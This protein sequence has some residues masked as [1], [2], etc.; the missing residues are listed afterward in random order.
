[1]FRAALKSPQMRNERMVTS[2]AKV[3]PHMSRVLQGMNNEE[4]LHTLN[5]YRSHV[6]P[7][8][9]DEQVKRK[10]CCYDLESATCETTTDNKPPFECPLFRVVQENKASINPVEYLVN[11]SKEISCPHLL[12]HAN[13]SS[14]VYAPA[15]DTCNSTSTNSLSKTN[16][17]GHLTS[18]KLIPVESPCE[19]RE[20]GSSPMPSET[21]SVASA[22][23]HLGHTGRRVVHAAPGDLMPCN[24][25]FDN[26]LK[27]IKHEGRYR[28]F[29]H[30]ARV[31]G[32]FPKTQYFHEDGCSVK[33]VTGWCTNDYLG[34]GQNPVVVSAMQR[35]VAEC[36]TGAGGTRNISGT[37]QYH[38]LL[39]RELAELH[40]KESALIFSSG[41]VANE[42][43]LSTLGKLLPK[44]VF[45]TDQYNHAS[46]I[47]GM[48]NARDAK[49]RIYRH[50]DLEHLEELLQNLAPDETAVIAYES[51]NS[52]EGTVAPMQEIAELAKKYN[53]ITFC[54]E[55]HAVGL[56]GN[57]GAG[58][59]ER[60]GVLDDTHIISGTL[61]KAYGVMGGYIAGSHAYI[62]A[63][64]ST[65]P[66]F[67]FTTSMTPA[68]A[69]AA[70]SSVRYLREHSKERNAMHINAVDLQARL[71]KR[72]F[73][74]MSTI[75]HITPLLVGDAEKC[76][77][78]SQMLMDEHDIYIQPINY[79][80][81][82]KGTERL[83][84]TATPVH[85]EEHKQ[86][87]IDSLENVWDYLDIPKIDGNMLHEDCPSLTNGAK[88]QL[89]CTMGKVR[90]EM[91]NKSRSA[92]AARA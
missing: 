70:L 21:S 72:G 75:S 84:I 57:S 54:D 31:A 86:H 77:A 30:L 53:A 73:P 64:R 34:M 15:L 59:A 8:I 25:V 42:A 58:V 81:V 62:D 37:N 28:T 4:T 90:M 41:F 36:G 71:F 88:K 33:T 47:E 38:V 65:A 87:L 20:N 9:N 23:T 18:Q 56:Y 22:P 32:E 91:I 10:K 13:A 6:D 80:T 85:L 27:G 60:D 19:E 16:K 67:I 69:A 17:N 82:P 89:K 51:V 52:M 35:A 49:R 61:G 63:V 50:N 40:Q 2:L 11:V 92:A 1:M 39:E 48:R 44:C 45:L 29:M 14:G 12:K 55:V 24:D 5:K 3:C 83:R 68:Q 79:P 76:K 66:G 7:T 74:V 46:M 78:A 43:S 26:V